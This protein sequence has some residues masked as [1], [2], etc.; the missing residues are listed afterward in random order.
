MITATEHQAP[1]R[2]SVTIFITFSFEMA[3]F[4]QRLSKA[5]WNNYNR[6]KSE[7]ASKTMPWLIYVPRIQNAP[8]LCQM[9]QNNLLHKNTEVI[10]DWLIEWHIIKETTKKYFKPFQVRNTP[11]LG[12]K[13]LIIQLWISNTW[14]WCQMS[15]P[16]SNPLA[17]HLFHLFIPSNY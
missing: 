15:L 12:K 5:T 13:H 9:W 10:K 17:P 14:I 16:Q 3:I 1:G 2:G 11:V 4:L 8:R 6:D 7:V